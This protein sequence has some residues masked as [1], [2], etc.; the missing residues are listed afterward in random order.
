MVAPFVTASGIGSSILLS[1][2]RKVRKTS[3]QVQIGK[4]NERKRKT[5]YAQAHARVTTLLAEEW[6]TPWEDCQTTAQVTA[7]VHG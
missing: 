1:P 7:Q 5:I 3:H 2:E 4:Q 6:A